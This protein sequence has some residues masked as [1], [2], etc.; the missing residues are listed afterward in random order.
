[1][2]F[3]SATPQGAA[4]TTTDTWITPRWII[5]AIGISDLDPCAYL[6]DGRPL[7]ETAKKYITEEQDGLKTSWSGTIFCNFPY[8]DGKIWMEKCRKYYEE[9]GCDVIIL[10]FARSDTKAWQENVRR[11]TGI[12][13]INR[14]IKFLDRMGVERGN[15]NAPSVLIAFGEAAYKRIGKVD[16]ILCRIEDERV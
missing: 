16:G 1:M 3:Q 2:S 12:N 9:T 7:V 6:V 13:L 4:H 14:R 10:C 5:D 11:A 8:S 15:G